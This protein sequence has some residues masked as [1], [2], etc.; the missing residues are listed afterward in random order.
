MYIT[1]DTYIKLVRFDVTKEH[2]ITFADGVAQVNY[3]ASLQGIELTASS[4][5]RQDFKIRFPACIDQIDRYN[6]AI[7][8]NKP[9]NYK[10]YFYY[11]TDM[12]YISDEVTDVIIKLDVF[13]TYQF[14]FHYLK[15]FVERE[16]ANTDVVGDNTIP[17]G[18]EKGEF[19]INKKENF[20][21][22]GRCVYIVTAKRDLDGE[23]VARN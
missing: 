1:K 8:Q 20:S 5:Q 21:G 13:Q 3:F 16:H 17:E 23:V 11:I 14:D 4:Y 12:E 18:L 7:V 15:S 9:E 19:I 10:Y 22:L 2:Q 6:Y